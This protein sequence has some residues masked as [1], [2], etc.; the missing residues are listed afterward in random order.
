MGENEEAAAADAKEPTKT[1]IDGHGDTA[2]ETSDAAAMAAMAA[3]TGFAMPEGQDM[4]DQI[5]NYLM[6][7]EQQFFNSVPEDVENDCTEMANASEIPVAKVPAS[8]ASEASPV[9]LVQ[10]L[11]ADAAVSNSSVTEVGEAAMAPTSIS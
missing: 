3:M 2:A 11:A 5:A 9:K 8:K 7:M 1:V 10:P 4:E 6:A